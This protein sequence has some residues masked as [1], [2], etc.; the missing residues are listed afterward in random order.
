MHSATCIYEATCTSVYATR[1]APSLA[2]DLRFSQ[3]NHHHPDRRAPGISRPVS[4]RVRRCLPLRVYRIYNLSCARDDQIAIYNYIQVAEGVCPYTCISVYA[5]SSA[6][7]SHWFA[8]QS[9]T[10]ITPIAVRPGYPDRRVQVSDGVYPYVYI[11]YI[12]CR[13]P[14]M[15]R[16]PYTA[17]NCCARGMARPAVY[18][19]IIARFGFPQR[20]TRMYMCRMTELGQVVTSALDPRKC[21]LRSR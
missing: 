21:A 1:R 10:I 19:S 17:M 15:I 12:T 6:R 16:P 3:K 9:Q 20:R 11:V 2:I 4:T 8:V 7:F 5:T 13:A 18:H 14:G